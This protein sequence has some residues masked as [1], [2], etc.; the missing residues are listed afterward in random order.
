MACIYLWGTKIFGVMSLKYTFAGVV[1]TISSSTFLLQNRELRPWGDWCKFLILLFL[2][3]SNVI[4]CLT[5]SN[6]YKLNL[7]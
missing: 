6:L 3:D 4:G 7:Q 5:S 1:L 2:D